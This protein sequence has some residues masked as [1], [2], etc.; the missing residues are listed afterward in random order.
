MLALE[1]HVSPL[2]MC[3]RRTFRHVF[4]HDKCVLFRA[5]PTLMWPCYGRSMDRSGAAYTHRLTRWPVAKQ[6]DTLTQSIGVSCGALAWGTGMAYEVGVY[7]A[8]SVGIEPTT[9]RPILAG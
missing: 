4:P 2:S 3:L 6:E 8:A 9:S 1:A 7:L 5:A